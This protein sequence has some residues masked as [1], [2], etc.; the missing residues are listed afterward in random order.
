MA[1]VEP[2]PTEAMLDGRYRLGVCVGEGGMARVYRGE[3][4]TLGRTVAIKMLRPTVDSVATPERARSETTVLAGLNHPSLVTLFDAHLVPGQPEYMVMEFVDGPTLSR[5]L[6]EGAMPAD[7]VAHLAADLAEAL[8]VVHSAGVVHRDIKPSNVLLAPSH[9]PGGRCRAKLADFGIAWLLDTTRVTAPGIVI[10][11][12]AYLAPE[13]VRGA[14][15]SPP[16]DIYS[17]GLVLLEALTG[18]RAYPEAEGIATA[19]ARLT[20]PPVIPASVGPRWAR[21]LTQMTDIDPA[22]RPTAAEIARTASEIAGDAPV[23][24]GAAAASAD[25]ATMPSAALATMA[26]AGMMVDPDHDLSRTRPL[27]VAA[28]ETGPAA[29]VAPRR[30][31]RAL[32]VGGWAAGSAVIAIAVGIWAAGIDAVPEPTPADTPVTERSVDPEP[33]SPTDAETVDGGT[34]PVVPADTGGGPGGGVGNEKAEEAQRKA[35]EKAAEE[36]RKAEEKA[37]KE[38]QKAE[39]DL[40][41]EA[42]EAQKKAEEEQRKAAEE[43]AEDQE[44]DG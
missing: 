18:S 2:P 21:L 19:L 27:P 36:A 32:L 10:G 24:S 41:K 34:V 14:Q 1:A 39:D 33:S 20:N 12:A 3:D 26:D 22:R 13:Q 43:A 16:A 23:V 30:R 35:A 17:L 8:H 6:A 31:R 42:E 15:P 4:V 40:R 11:T 9:L 5:R 37:A 25:M 29:R 44:D 28:S 7:E 38:A